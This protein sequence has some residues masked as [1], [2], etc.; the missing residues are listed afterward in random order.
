MSVVPPELLKLIARRSHPT[1]ARAIKCLN[2]T[3]LA[4]I[5]ETDLRVGESHHRLSTTNLS[6]CLYWAARNGHVE[7][8]KLILSHPHTNPEESIQEVDKTVALVWA[9]LRGQADIVSL[10]LCHGAEV[11]A[12][13]LS[14]E[15]KDLGTVERILKTVYDQEDS[16]PENLAKPFSQTYLP[17]TAAAQGGHVAV[18]SLLLEAGANIHLHREGALRAAVERGGYTVVSQLIAVGA[19]VQ[20]EGDI[21]YHACKGGLCADSSSPPRSW[22]I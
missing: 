15:D 22:S 1:A 18:V 21:L 5:T 9:S 11:F 4:L 19:N 17:L 7:I 3:T 20:S 2:K 12:S 13:D 8:T 14:N 6:N 10:L 16:L